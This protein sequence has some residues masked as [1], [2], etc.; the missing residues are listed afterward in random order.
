V[1]PIVL[2]VPADHPCA[3]GHFPGNPIVPGAVLLDWILAAIERALGRSPSVWA[4]K[5]A[6]FLHPTRPGDE[7]ELE[8][9]PT[10][11][12]DI[13]FDCRSGAQAVVT[14][15]VRSTDTPAEPGVGG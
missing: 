12:G 2:R 15:V 1:S 6:K 11:G 3:G 7:L 4:I 5:S 8:F 10:T 13:R 14:G 9:A